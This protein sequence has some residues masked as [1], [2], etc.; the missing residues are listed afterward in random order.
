MT[1]LSDTLRL[2]M[3]SQWILKPL[4]Q[5]HFYRTDVFLKFSKQYQCTVNVFQQD[6]K[7]LYYTN[8]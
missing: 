8:N 6:Y 1:I 2:T 4:K 7:E 5:T 3:V